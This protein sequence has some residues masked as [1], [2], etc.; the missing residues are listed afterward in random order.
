MKVEEV[1]LATAIGAGPSV[2]L[3]ALR[4]SYVVKPIQQVPLVVPHSEAEAVELTGPPACRGN[5]D[6][7]HV[8]RG[9]V[10]TAGIAH[11]SDA[12]SDS[13]FRHSFVGQATLH[14]AAAHHEADN[15]KVHTHALSD[16][17]GLW[18]IG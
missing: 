4:A 18:S 10:R 13:D 8:I 3:G 16:G 9:N 2:W 11:L 12:W 7:R 1:Q 17:T 15:V 6:H 14:Q 5:S